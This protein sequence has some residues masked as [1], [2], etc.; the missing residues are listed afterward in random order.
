[1]ATAKCGC[2]KMNWIEHGSA[3]ACVKC[4]A[5]LSGSPGAAA[6]AVASYAAPAPVPA[7]EPRRATCPSCRG[8]VPAG[9]PRC[10]TCGWDAKL[11]MRQCVACPGVVQE[12]YPID[13]GAMGAVG[14]I[15]CFLVFFLFGILGGMMIFCGI[16]A[17]LAVVN[18]LCARIKCLKC[19]RG[20]KGAHLTEEERKSLLGLRLKFFG[21][22]VLLGVIAVGLLVLLVA[23]VVT[24]K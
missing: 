14:G 9:E 21:S 16:G 11:Q 5:T 23:L 17:V 4:G 19:S 7:P 2:G 3:A 24:L 8:P 6:V 13:I 12:D 10:P 22:A 20:V 18:G 15:A 1:M